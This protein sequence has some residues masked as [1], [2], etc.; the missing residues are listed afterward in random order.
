MQSN[1]SDFSAFCFE[2]A[3]FSSSLISSYTTTR[4]Y[5]RTTTRSTTQ[6]RLVGSHSSPPR[7]HLAN[8]LL[9]RDSLLDY[10]RSIVVSIVLRCSFFDSWRLPWSKEQQMGCHFLL[11]PSPH[12]FTNNQTP[13]RLLNPIPTIR[14][15]TSI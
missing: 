1:T 5:I 8:L 10:A 3:L 15:S 12:K 13:K 11:T 4:T 6:R 2:K 14:Q 7:L 9:T